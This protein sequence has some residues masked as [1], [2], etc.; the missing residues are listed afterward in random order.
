M[1]VEVAYARGV[2]YKYEAGAW[3]QAKGEKICRVSIWGH[4]KSSTEA[5]IVAQVEGSGEVRFS[6]F[7]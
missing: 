6:P 1:E 3:K 2:I 7:C 5:R 4:E